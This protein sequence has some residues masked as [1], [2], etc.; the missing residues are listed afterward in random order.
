M[1]TPLQGLD[2]VDTLLKIVTANKWNLEEYSVLFQEW[3]I[4]LLSLIDFDQDPHICLQE[5]LSSELP[6]ARRYRTFLDEKVSTSC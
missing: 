5:M 3:F 2:F 4:L 6:V 1:L